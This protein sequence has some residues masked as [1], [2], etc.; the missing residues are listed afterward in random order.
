MNGIGDNKSTRIAEK[1]YH[2]WERDGRPDGRSLDHWLQAEADVAGEA[3]PD[4]P[5][6]RK[7]RSPSKP[8]SAKR[9]TATAETAE[10]KAGRP[11]TVNKSPV[12]K[13]RGQ[14]GLTA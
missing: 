4:G 5:E 11:G 10:M 3:A 14:A 8:Q 1:A 9:G 7:A 2:L 6:G 12:K 13:S